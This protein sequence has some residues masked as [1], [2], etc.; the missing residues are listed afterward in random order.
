MED[1]F[2]MAA[3]TILLCVIHL[4]HEHPT[5]AKSRAKI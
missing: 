5:I 2:K 3:Y 4:S 1:Q